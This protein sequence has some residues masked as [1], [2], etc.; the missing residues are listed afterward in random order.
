MELAGDPAHTTK[1]ITA[2]VSFPDIA[3]ENSLVENQAASAFPEETPEREGAGVSVSQF[4]PPPMPPPIATPVP[5][6]P[7]L[8]VEVSAPVPVP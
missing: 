6:P 2:N 8:A 5:P 3:N 4:S 7:P 1:H